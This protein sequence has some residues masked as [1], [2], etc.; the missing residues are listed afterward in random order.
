MRRSTNRGVCVHVCA[1]RMCICVCLERRRSR[2]EVRDGGFRSPLTSARLRPPWTEETWPPSSPPLPLRSLR[3][4]FRPDKPPRRTSDPGMSFY[5]R[6]ERTQRFIVNWKIRH[7]R[8]TGAAGIRPTDEGVKALRL[9]VPVDSQEVDRD[10]GEHDGQA[11]ATHNGLR[12]QGEDEQEGPE[13]EV[14]DRPYQADLK[15]QHGKKILKYFQLQTNPYRFPIFPWFW[16]SAFSFQA[17]RRDTTSSNDDEEKYHLNA[18]W[19]A[20]AS[21][22]V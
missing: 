1:P 13:H 8:S 22:A 18:P 17:M 7:L 15:G 6:R 21:W 5:L 10:A 20:G 4:C 9:V 12:V 19:L 16:Q 11:G 14:N 3:C 2:L